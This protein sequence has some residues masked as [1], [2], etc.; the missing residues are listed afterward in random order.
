METFTLVPNLPNPIVECHNLN[1]PI[2]TNA[3]FSHNSGYDTTDGHKRYVAKTFDHN[4]AKISYFTDMMYNNVIPL[5]HSH[6]RFNWSWPIK[7]ETL[8]DNIIIKVSLVKD[9]I[10]FQQ[11]KHEDPRTFVISGILHLQ[12]CEQGTYFTDS[13]YTAPT[14]KFSGA[15]WSNSQRSYHLVPKVTSERLAYLVI[16]QW[17]S[18]PNYRPK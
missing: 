8:L 5:L 17:K 11:P 2:P 12:D 16:V 1:L 15:F 9:E 10:G 4:D 18:L 14:K 3:E 13:Q 7:L 6:E